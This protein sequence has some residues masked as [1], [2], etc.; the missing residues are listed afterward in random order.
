MQIFVKTLTGKTITLEV[1]SSDTIENVKTKIQDKEGIPPDQQRLI[2][3]GKQL[4]DG[5]T[6]SDYNIQKESTLHLVL[7]LRGGMQIFVKTLTGKTITL[8]VESSDT[9]DNVKAKIQ[10]KEGIPPDQQRLIFAGKQLEDGR[11]L[12]DYNIQKEST[13]HLVLRLRGGMQIFVK[14][15]TGKTITLEV[16]SSDTIDNVKAK[17]QDKEGIPPDQQR[18][19]FAGKQL[20]DGRTLSDYNI[21]KESTLH[22][23]LRLRGG[24]TGETSSQLLLSS[25]ANPLQ[26]EPRT[27]EARLDGKATS[28]PFAMPPYYYHLKFELYATPDPTANANASGNQGG[29]SSHKTTARAADHD[30]NIWIPAPGASIFDE[31]PSHPRTRTRTRQLPPPQQQPIPQRWR[32]WDLGGLDWSYDHEYERKGNDRARTVID[33]GAQRGRAHHHDTDESRREAV[34]LSERQ[35]RAARQQDEAAGSL[36]SSLPPGVEHGIGADKAVRDWRFGRVRVESFDLPAEDTEDIEMAGKQEGEAA[37]AATPAASLGPNLGGMGLA[38]KAR[39]V[40]LETKNTEVGWGVVHL[41]REGEE[42][43]VVRGVQEVQEVQDGPGEGNSKGLEGSGGGDEEG[44]ILCVPAVPS[45]MSPSDFLGFIGEK[46]RGYVSHYRMVMT[47]RMNRYMVLMK[48]RDSRRAREWRKEFDGKPFDSVETEIC[49]VTFIKSITVETPTQTNIQRKHSEGNNDR[50]SPTSPLVNSLKPFPPPTPNLIELPTCA[51]CLERMDDTTG[52]MTIL[53]QHVFHCTCLQTWKGSGCPVCRATNPKP[54]EEY[55]PDNPYSQPFG[56]GVANI[57]NNCNCTDDLWICLICGNV[58]CGRYNG[59][60][61]KEHW[62]LTAHSFSL[63]LE[64]QHVWDY[65]GDMWVHRLIRD[66]GDGKVVELPRNTTNDPRSGAATTAPGGE[67]GPPQEDVVPRAKLDSI[68]MEYTHLLTSQLE[69]Q[70][71]YFEEMVSKAADKAAKASAA[72]ESAS[73][74]AGEALRQ[75]AALREEHRVLR[76]ETVPSLEKE[77]AKEKNRAAKSAELARSL[78]KALQEEKEV[79]AGLLARI[80]HVRG[81]SEGTGRVVEQLRAENEELKEMNRDLT[82]FISGQEKLREM[83]KEGMVEQGELE[84]GT[85]GVAEGSGGKRKGKGRK[86]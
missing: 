45:Y 74:Q 12:S 80:E 53:C 8:E 7:R 49:H 30:H 63:E 78:S 6:L 62:K 72:A 55:D 20:E 35:F 48:F 61:A 64:T 10:D 50:F 21:Q 42:S 11:T 52:L 24:H 37:A 27:L 15:L 84:D 23:V 22:L 68:G 57:C 71:V 32:Q 33:C 1:E 60:H 18:L 85:V 29:S 47:S 58:G 77:L 39:Y 54:T 17:I 25:D 76:D 67:G 19:I 38:T 16:E 41:Y 59:G 81:E 79:G 44:T 46:W 70:R 31:L 28:F 73:A 34:R 75:L 66:K 5:R 3:A 69:S 26:H 40:P 86:K 56:S 83:E 36:S 43:S 4:E 51:V 82:M 65:A 13:L 9:I 2:F 14:T